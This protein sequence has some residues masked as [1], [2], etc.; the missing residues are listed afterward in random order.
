MADNTTALT[1]SQCPY[2]AISSPPNTTTTTTSRGG[3]DGVQVCMADFLWAAK[4]VQPSAKREGFAVV[5]DVTWKD[6]GALAEV[7]SPS[8]TR[9]LML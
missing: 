1:V 8:T 4:S 2:C 5:P 9:Q 6:V 7:T 3:V